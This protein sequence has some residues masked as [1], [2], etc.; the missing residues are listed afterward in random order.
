MSVR[1]PLIRVLRSGLRALGDPMHRKHLWYHH[2]RRRAAPG[3]DSWTAN[4]WTAEDRYPGAFSYVADALGRDSAPRIL[5][6]GCATGEEVFTLRRY[7]PN[8][9]IRGIDVDAA[10]IAT[11]RKRLAARGGDSR[12]AFEVAGS[13][14][15]EA[16]A[17][18]EAIFC[19]AVLRDDRVSAPG[20]THCDPHIMFADFARTIADFARCL[21]PGGYLIVRHSNFRLCDT[22]GAP[23]FRAVLAN[24]GRSETLLFG[25]DNRLLE[26]AVYP[27]TVFL[28]LPG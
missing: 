28:R 24:P 25:P 12:L 11:A 26:E 27:D 4:G 6:F 13:T 23:L 7:L 14:A 9:D 21:R 1:P 15:G 10:S 22:P 20:T 5:S 17:G 19:M 3:A 16:D 2:I 8:A 18:Y